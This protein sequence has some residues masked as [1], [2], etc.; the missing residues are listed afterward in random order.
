MYAS[1]IANPIFSP[2]RRRR[3]QEYASA[4]R[5]LPMRQE[6][7]FS[8]G[9]E[10][11]FIRIKC[12]AKKNLGLARSYNLGINKSKTKY[13]NITLQFFKTGPI[14]EDEIEEALEG[15]DRSEYSDIVSNIARYCIN[16]VP[17]IS[18]F[19]TRGCS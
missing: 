8:L 2:R 13:A 14:N 5:L 1:L 3:Y 17:N 7:F 10:A 11:R 9:T 6:E 19:N 12:K 16:E 15:R 4:L 18:D